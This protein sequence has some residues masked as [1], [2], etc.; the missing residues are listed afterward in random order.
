MYIYSE[1]PHVSSCIVQLGKTRQQSKKRGKMGVRGGYSRQVGSSKIFHSRVVETFFSLSGFALT[2]N[3]QLMVRTI[4]IKD[5]IQGKTIWGA[6]MKE[7]PLGD[8]KKARD[9]IWTI[10]NI[11]SFL[12]VGAISVISYTVDQRYCLIL[13]ILAPRTQH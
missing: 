11:K 13:C 9:V 3:R 4:L 1:M 6:R 2:F 5:Q 8:V 12:S 7:M 10:L